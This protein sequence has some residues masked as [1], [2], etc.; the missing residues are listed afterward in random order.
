[1]MINR[2]GV[3]ISLYLL[4]VVV[5]AGQANAENGQ[6]KRFSQSASL[7]EQCESLERDPANLRHLLD[8][9][10]KNDLDQYGTGYDSFLGG[11][12]EMCGY[13][14]EAT[15]IIQSTQFS[16]RTKDY[17]NF[18][19]AIQLPF[20]DYVNSWLPAVFSGYEN[21]TV[22]EGQLIE[23]LFSLSR[24]DIYL[25][26]QSEDVQNFYKSVVAR[27]P[28]LGA[29]KSPFK[30]WR[31]VA[32]AIGAVL[33]GSMAKTIKVWMKSGEVEQNLSNYNLSMDCRKLLSKRR[34][35]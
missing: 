20:D 14:V 34:A 11:R 17:L 19:M 8:C 9:I 31:S 3:N 6:E 33:D 25:E 22:T 12:L 29:K 35:Q 4:F 10:M 27:D 18:N 2:F 1:M 13:L 21:G 24:V 26:Y 30:Q 16:A 5:F 28:A 32:D 15:Q 23:V 7:L